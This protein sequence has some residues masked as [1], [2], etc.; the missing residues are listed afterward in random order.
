MTFAHAGSI[1]VASRLS[2]DEAS[3]L[4][5]HVPDAIRAEH[6]GGKLYTLD[7]APDINYRKDLFIFF[8]LHTKGDGVKTTLLENG[9]IGYFAVNK[10]TGQV[11]NGLPEFGAITGKSLSKLQ[12]KL[13][14]AHCIGKAL[15]AKYNDVTPAG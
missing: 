1:C 4:V 2:D 13:R 14:S 8:E 6:A 7:Y 10:I 3:Q 5:M 11:F 12:S 9:L 15:T